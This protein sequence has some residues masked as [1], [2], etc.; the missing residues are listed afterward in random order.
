MAKF[1]YDGRIPTN[2]VAVSSFLQRVR[3]L[4]GEGV[5]MLQDE[6]DSFHRTELF[7]FC[8]HILTK[9]NDQRL[10]GMVYFSPRAIGQMNLNLATVSLEIIGKHLQQSVIDASFYESAVTSIVRHYDDTLGLSLLSAYGDV[11]KPGH[12]QVES[13]FVPQGAD[14]DLQMSHHLTRIKA[15]GLK[16]RDALEKT[17]NAFRRAELPLA[18]ETY[19][20]GELEED[21]TESVEKLITNLIKEDKLSA[22]YVEACRKVLGDG[23]FIDCC[24]KSLGEDQGMRSIRKLTSIFDES[25]F[26]T[27]S[28]VQSFKWHPTRETQP[29]Y[30]QKFINAGADERQFPILANAVLQNLDKTTR[31]SGDNIEQMSFV[32]GVI[33]MA[34]RMGVGKEAVTNF[35][36]NFRS[37]APDGAD[38]SMVASALCKQ[39]YEIQTLA[40][41]RVYSLLLGAIGIVGHNVLHQIAPAVPGRLIGDLVELSKLDASPR[42]LANLFP[43]ARGFVLENDLGI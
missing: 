43:Q 32:R 17:C 22:S 19:L 36:S 15:V 38:L 11:L 41:L 12:G 34:N 10:L 21:C 39:R 9:T 27:P 2:D 14:L 7:T 3:S 40:S 13:T 1:F 24:R 5:R 16:P 23:F 30:L 29:V 26:H 25:V 6:I 42:E 4:D 37:F 33:T 20:K 31:I 18:L 8:Q 28:L 35:I